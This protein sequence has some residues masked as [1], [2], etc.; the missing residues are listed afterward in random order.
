[1]K[2]RPIP[3]SAPMVRAILDGTKT[4]TRRI[5][6]PQLEIVNVEGLF[7]SWALPM[8][9]NRHLLYPNAKQPVLDKCPY[10]KPG[11]Q[12][13]VRERFQPLWADGFDWD[14]QVKPDYKTGFGYDISYPA[15]DGIVE[16]IDGDDNITD[17]CRP[18]IHMPRWASRILLEIVSVR[19]ERL[20]DI[21]KPDAE[22]EGIEGIDRPTGGDD[23]ETHYR[24]YS[25]STDDADGWPY[26]P[27]GKQVQSYKTLWEKING[28]GSWDKN[29]WVWVV[30][31]KRV[32]PGAA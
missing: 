16:W 22:A 26:F 9:G 8:K 32:E 3:F 12:L 15:T 17:R 19:V 6:K 27:D 30:E 28:T 7:Q 21:S 14:S 2:E 4:Q 1:M 11:D 24:D 25:L 29:P 23:Y 18:S 31:F 13:W 20:N 10:G 5:M